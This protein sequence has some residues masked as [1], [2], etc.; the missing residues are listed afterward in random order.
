MAAIVPAL[1]ALPPGGI[2]A[3]PDGIAAD[4]APLVRANLDGDALA[5]RMRTSVA[6][7]RR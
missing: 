2:A 3:K 4:L 1:A 6:L 7:V 5:Y